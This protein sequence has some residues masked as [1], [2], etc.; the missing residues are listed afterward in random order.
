[1]DDPDGNIYPPMERVVETYF[2]AYRQTLERMRNVPDSAYVLGDTLPDFHQHRCSN[3]Q[4]TN[5]PLMM[6]CWRWLKIS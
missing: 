2:H 4:L 3:F 6:A 1:M 5:T